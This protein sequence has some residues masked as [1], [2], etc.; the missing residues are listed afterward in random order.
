MYCENIIILCCSELF[1]HIVAILRIKA[2]NN[3]MLHFV[4][5]TEKQITKLLF[6]QIIFFLLSSVDREKYGNNSFRSNITM[7]YNEFINKKNC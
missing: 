3:R 5:M 4:L 6:C 2:F 7:L 1:N